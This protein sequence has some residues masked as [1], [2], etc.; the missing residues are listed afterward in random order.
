MNASSPPPRPQS[1]A[2]GLEPRQWVQR[3][4]DQLYNY[5]IGRLKNHDMAEEAVQDTF[6]TAVVSLENFEG[7]STERT[8]LFSILKRK[9]IDVI[10]R[11][12]KRRS[13]FTLYD[14]VNPESLLFS[15]DGTWRR[16][17]FAQSDCPVESRELWQIVQLCLGLLPSNQAN[18]F[19]LRVLEEKTSAEIC[20]ELE[21][22]PSNLGI[23][24]H[25]A[26]LGLARC[27]AEKMKK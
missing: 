20:E 25:R 26:R 16:N 19:V 8:W 11:E 5:A 3:Y 18:V 13:T 14:E 21:I 23:R 15:P 24:L 12:W 22:S 17:W 2:A 27:V 4:G 9:I 10:R 6:V 7:K 1:N